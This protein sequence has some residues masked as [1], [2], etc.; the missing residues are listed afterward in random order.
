MADRVFGRE[1][2]RFNP[3]TPATSVSP[4]ASPGSNAAGYIPYTPPVNATPGQTQAPSPQVTPPGYTGPSARPN[5]SPGSNDSINKMWAYDVAT[6]YNPTMNNNLMHNYNLQK[7]AYELNGGRRWVGDNVNGRWIT[8]APVAPIFTS[9]DFDQNLDWTNQNTPG[10]PQYGQSNP[11]FM[12]PYMQQDASYAGTLTPWTSANTNL[13]AAHTSMIPD[14]GKPN[15]VNFPNGIAPGS[16]MNAYN[17]M[18]VSPTQEVFA[19]GGNRFSGGNAPAQY[20]TPPQGGG[21]T[22]GSQGGQNANNPLLSILS[23]LLG[24]GQK[25]PSP[26]FNNQR[27]LF[28]PNTSRGDMASQALN[29]NGGSAGSS[30]GNPLLTILQALLGGG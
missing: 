4:V 19:N 14:A 21:Q 22:A 16:G 3:T 8:D 20:S 7:E 24:G 13:S 25:Q 30:S 11:D 10:Q 1:N 26:F 23:L 27:S 6:N 18:G 15:T 29:N 28:Y 2:S 17:M 9:T 12:R 5:W